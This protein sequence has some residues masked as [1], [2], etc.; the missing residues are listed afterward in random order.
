MAYFVPQSRES[1]SRITGVGANKLEEYGEIFVKHIR[2]YAEQHG[3][4]ERERHLNHASHAP[5]A[6]PARPTRRR[7]DCSGKG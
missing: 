2:E 1:F 4:E 5:S 6:G 7:W 3:L